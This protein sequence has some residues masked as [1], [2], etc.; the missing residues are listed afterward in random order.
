MKTRIIF[1]GLFLLAIL[2]TVA[3]L[4]S[5]NKRPSASYAGADVKELR[6]RIKH[7]E[8]LTAALEKKLSDK[9]D[10]PVT[11]ATFSPDGKTIIT[12]DKQARIWD[13]RNGKEITPS[14]PNP[15]QP[16]PSANPSPGSIP[17]GW[18]AHEF[19]GMTYYVV[20]L[21]TR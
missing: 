8:E 2:A 9:R 17:P 4:L 10:N 20:P 19:N 7:L 12:G 6:E 13:A 1:A 14:I 3:L 11:H 21:T 18:K 16:A 15:T 5:S